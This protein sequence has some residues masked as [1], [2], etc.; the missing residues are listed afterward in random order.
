MQGHLRDLTQRHI[1]GYKVGTKQQHC[2]EGNSYAGT[3]AAPYAKA[4]HWLIRADREAAPTTVWRSTG[5]NLPEQPSMHAAS[6][7]GTPAAILPFDFV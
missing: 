3:S 5:L 1:T 4:H 6:I 7:N 2:L